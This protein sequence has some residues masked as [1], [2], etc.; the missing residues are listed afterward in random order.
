MP[1]K[2][3]ILATPIGN[4]KDITLRAIEVLKSVDFL[5]AEDTRVTLKLLNH[6]GL[7]KPMFSYFRHSNPEKLNS[8][9]QKLQSGQTAA[10]VSDAGMPCISD[11]GEELVK[12]CIVQGINLEPIPGANA[13]LSALVASGLNTTRFCFEGFLPMNKK[14]RTARLKKL[15]QEERTIIFY[16]APHKLLSTLKDMQQTFGRDRKIC[17]AKELTKIH[18]QFLR[19]CLAQAVKY[20]EHEQPKGEFVLILKGAEET[21]AKKLNQAEIIKE[22]QELQKAGKSKTEIAKELAEK[23]TLSRQEIYNL[24]HG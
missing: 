1:G 16:E 22:A 21:Q 15:Q 14:N 3:Y 23:S 17:I 9:L 12:A 10:I 7:K 2:L 5:V 19:F 20:F 24:L 6:L 4:L 11:P 18:E 13:A 8:I